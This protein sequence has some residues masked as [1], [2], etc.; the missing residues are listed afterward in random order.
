MPC[1]SS[2][3]FQTPLLSRVK[4]E[5][6]SN[7]V[8]VLS[9]DSDVQ[10]TKVGFPQRTPTYLAAELTPKTAPL[11]VSIPG[12]GNAEGSVV[13]YLRELRSLKGC[14]NVLFKLE[15]DSIPVHRVIV[16]PPLFN[17]DVIFELPTCNAIG[18][19]SH[20]TQMAGMDKQYDGH[21]W[22]KTVT[23]NIFNR[24]GL[25]F[26]KSSYLGH[27]CCVNGNCKFLSCIHRMKDVNELEWK[28]QSH[29]PLDVGEGHPP[30]SSL[31]C[32]IYR[33]PLACIAHCSAQVYYVVGNFSTTRAF[34]H[35]GS[36]VH[37]VKDGELSDI[38]LRS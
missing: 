38:Q 36:H 4:V 32:K 7:I 23:T 11:Q 35:L 19:S 2:R 1:S 20:A 33:V 27:L 15:Y 16:L 29:V 26:R 10:E 21:V 5:P 13:A 3:S 8:T 37:L 34:V 14:K 18:T 17:G 28:R 24:M 12:A 6:Q 22:S 31:V 30:G 25:T 9:S